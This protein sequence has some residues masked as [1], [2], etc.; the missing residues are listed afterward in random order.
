VET[1]EPA[2]PRWRRL[3]TALT[4]ETPL[5]LP[6]WQPPIVLLGAFVLAWLRI[7]SSGP[8]GV[9]WA[10][11]GAVFLTRSYTSRI[12]QAFLEPYAGY[13]QAVPRT[14]TEF[15]SWFPPTW[16]GT[17]ITA[18]A[19]L[20]VALAALTVFLVVVSHTRRI[21]PAV[22]GA[23]AVAAVPLGFETVVNLANVQWYWWA[24]GLLA[25][26]WAPRS[27]AAQGC[28]AAALLLTNVLS[29]F[30]LTATALAFVVAALTRSRRAGLV[31]LAGVVGAGIQLSVMLNA[32]RGKE[33][34]D[35]VRPADLMLGYVRWVIGDG[36]LGA[37]RHDL[38]TTPPSALA[39]AVIGIALLALAFAVCRTDP[40]RVAVTAVLWVGSFACYAVPVVLNGTDLRSPVADARYYVTPAIL[41][42][43]STA[44]L[45]ASAWQRSALPPPVARVLVAGLAAAS[46]FGLGTSWQIA[47][48]DPRRDAPGWAELVDDA[49]EICPPG[50]TVQVPIQ[51]PPFVVSAP[52]AE[53]TR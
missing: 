1:T 7:G 21:A 26:L 29:P 36:F 25:M 35:S 22:L 33:L 51:P 30:G 20:L 39:G 14:F 24:A 34:A 50:A 48:S 5:G 27:Q 11:D 13:V 16:Q 17:V 49:V 8:R 37:R 2:P 52:C 19:S 42:L 28:Q 15:A 53:L 46:V 18:S 41:L 40:F 10:E 44:M 32:E 43:T 38:A 4:P 47:A 45:A 3:G 12:D 6:R 23:V 9:L 31:A